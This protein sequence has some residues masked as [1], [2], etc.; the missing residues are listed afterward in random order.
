MNRGSARSIPALVKHVLAGRLDLDVM[1]SAERPLDD[2]P[3]TL[4]DLRAGK[5]LGRSVIVL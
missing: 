5:V 3:A 1:V 4:D 2:L